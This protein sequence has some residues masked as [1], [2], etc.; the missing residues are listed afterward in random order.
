MI[1]STSNPKVKRLVALRK[2][3]KA[4]DEEDIFLTEGIRMFREI[5]ADMLKELYVSEEYYRNEKRLVEEKAKEAGIVPEVFSDHVYAY[6]S[7]TRTPQGVLCV[8]GRKS[9]LSE[10]E[11]LSADRAGRKPL[12]IVL[13]NLQDP[14]NLGTIVRTGEG[15]GVTGIFM[16]RDCVD[17]YNPKTIRS[18]MG[19][20]Y[21]MPC[22]Y[23]EDMQGLLEKMKKMNIHT[24]A[25]HLE[26]QTDYDGEDYTEGCAFLIGNEGNGLRR[27]VADMAD[28]YIRIPMEGK[29]ESLNAAIAATVLMFEA[30]RQR[31]RSKAV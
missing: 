21:R 15:A 8:A 25:A 9:Q 16:S 24:F 17:L 2:K 12:L 4:R 29:V 31:R 7:D 11:M 30:G 1:T 27:E 22:R 3:R 14:G 6:V 23:V 5:P 13:D 28:T 19:S 18:T 10:D 26:G 20:I